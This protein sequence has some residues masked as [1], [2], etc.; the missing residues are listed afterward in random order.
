E[1]GYPAY[2]GS[3]LAQF[4][5]RAGRVIS[6][7]SDGREGALSAIGAVSP[8]GGDISE[9][10]SQATL[11]IVKVFW[12]LDASL[13]Y[14][15]HFPAINWL[16]SYS[17]YTDSLAGWYEKNVAPDWMTLRGQIM[18]LLQ[19]E[20][21]LEE[22]V[23]LVGMDAL[24]AP[25][26]LKMEAARSVREDFLHQ[27]AFHEVDTYTSLHKQY[28]MMQLVLKYFD[29][30]N[31]ALESGADIEK[32]A[33]LPV[34]ERIGRFKYVSEDAIDEEYERVLSQMDEELRQS[35]VKEE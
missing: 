21:A 25:D 2:L 5:E 6:L 13:A 10:V 8:P 9:P 15:R 23:R 27:L 18:R 7:G 19:D 28:R 34:R 16:T 11:R 22:I 33:G 4:Y 26:R 20:A 29:K 12:G 30:S 17:L 31:Q 14:K 35:L 1:E 32:L 24:S 3:R